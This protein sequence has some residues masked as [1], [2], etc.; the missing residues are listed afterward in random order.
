MYM[1]TIS[2]MLYLLICVT[3]LTPFWKKMDVSVCWLSDKPKWLNKP[4]ITYQDHGNTAQTIR[5]I[6]YGQFDDP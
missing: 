3:Q 5:A 2:D 4:K 1:Q 6:I